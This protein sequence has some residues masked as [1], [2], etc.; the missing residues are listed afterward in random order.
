MREKS[1]WEQ[2]AESLFKQGKRPTPDPVL[3][4]G[5]APP[6]PDHIEALPSKPISGEITP[7]NKG[8][9]RME[10]TVD[11]AQIIGGVILHET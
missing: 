9:S 8:M 5:D 3:D 2:V 10:K 7:L 11:M 6:T 1:P 4:G